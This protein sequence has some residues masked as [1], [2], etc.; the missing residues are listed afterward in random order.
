MARKEKNSTV[1]QWEKYQTD[2][3]EHKA[4]QNYN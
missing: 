4:D 1:I 3:N 2:K